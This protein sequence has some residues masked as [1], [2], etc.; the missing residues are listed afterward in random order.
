MEIEGSQIYTHLT[1]VPRMCTPVGV[2]LAGTV[3]SNGVCVLRVFVMI[4]VFVNK[5][6]YRLF[7]R[8][9]RTTYDL[10]RD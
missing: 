2:L 9:V 4:R 3:S 8:N 5:E 6:I 7:V 10:L 1:C